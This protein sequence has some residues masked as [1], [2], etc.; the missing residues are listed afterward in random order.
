MSQGK[1]FKEKKQQRNPSMASSQG[2]ECLGF[3]YTPVTEPDRP[4]EYIF[5]LPCVS[6]NVTKHRVRG[7]ALEP[8]IIW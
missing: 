1:V 6:I 7:Y 8:E 3:Q 5:M 4:N 2:G